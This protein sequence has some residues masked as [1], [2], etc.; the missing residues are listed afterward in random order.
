MAN[1]IVKTQFLLLERA[2]LKGIP[3]A[4]PAPAQ[5]KAMDRADWSVCIYSA[6]LFCSRGPLRLSVNVGGL[7]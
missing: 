7:E 2:S 1:G 4:A 5:A 3:T 6:R